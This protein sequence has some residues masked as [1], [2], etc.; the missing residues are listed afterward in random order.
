V[1]DKANV[2]DVE[3]LERFRSVLV[4]FIERLNSLLDEVSEEV[5][6]TRICSRQ[7]RSFH[8]SMK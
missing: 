4:V 6:R 2:S 3:A 5:K 8:F 1:A 7:I